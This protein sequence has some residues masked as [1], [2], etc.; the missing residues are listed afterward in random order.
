MKKLA[1]LFCCT[2]ILFGAVSAY[3]IWDLIAPTSPIDFRI[4]E[5]DAELIYEGSRRYSLLYIDE[6]DWRSINSFRN[7]MN[8][9][10]AV[11]NAQRLVFDN[12]YNTAREP[13]L[14]Y[15]DVENG[16]YIVLADSTSGRAVYR[17]LICDKT[18]GTMSAPNILLRSSVRALPEWE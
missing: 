3:F 2:T 12:P 16:F 10:W 5:V 13:Y 7:E 4:I 14:V 6:G 11:H 17:V 1:I 18:G 9:L 8:P 15:H